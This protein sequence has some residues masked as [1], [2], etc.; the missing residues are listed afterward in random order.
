MLDHALRQQREIQKKKKAEEERQVLQEQKNSMLKARQRQ[1][2]ALSCNSGPEMDDNEL[3]CIRQIELMTDCN[4][5]LKEI[6]GL[7]LDQ[8]RRFVHTPKDGFQPPED[9]T[10][11]LK[12][13]AEN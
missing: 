13:Y 4:L 12:H 3:A 8:C 10:F 5:E 9:Q 6:K 2:D 1:E 11:Y 7:D